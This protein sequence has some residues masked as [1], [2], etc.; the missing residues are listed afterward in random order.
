MGIDD[1]N[2]KS[3]PVATLLLIKNTNSKDRKDDSFHCRSAIRSLSCLARCTRPDMSIAVYQV[4][5]FS[6]NLKASHDTAVKRIGKCLLGTEDKELT[7]KPDNSKG[8]QI[9]VDADF[10]GAFDKAVA[11]DPAS[12]YSRTGFVIKYARCLII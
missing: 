7:C 2:P 9:F 3:T 4:A 12:V 10:A 11:E 6:N 8:L 5:K 1:T